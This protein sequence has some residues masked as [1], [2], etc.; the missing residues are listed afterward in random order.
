VRVYS[1]NQWQQLGSD[2][3]GEASYDN[4]GYSTYMNSLGTRLVIGAIY[5]DGPGGK[6]NCGH[7]R[8][9]QWSTS[10]TQLGQDIDG[11]ASSDLFGSSVSMNSVGNIIAVGAPEFNGTAGNN[12]GRVKVFSLNVNNWVQ[13]GSSIDGQTANEY[14]G[15]S[16]SLNA[17]GFTLAIGAP[18]WDGTGA[19]DSGKVRVYSYNGSS[20]NQAGQDLDGT[21]GDQFGRCVSLNAAGNTLAVGAPY[22]GAGD[23]GYVKIYKLSG[24]TWI[25]VGQTITGILTNDQ[26]GY[27]I[28]L[29]EAGNKIAI[30]APNAGSSSRGIAKVYDLIEN[31]W[32]QMGTDIIGKSP[33][34]NAGHSVSLNAVGDRLLIGNPDS[35]S[36]FGLTNTARA[37]Y[38][39][40]SV[41]NQLGPSINGET[42]NDQNG[43]SVSMNAEGDRIAVAAIQS[44]N[45]TNTKPACGQVRVF[46]L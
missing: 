44:N 25:Q 13:V 6:P 5:N 8:V 42:I 27:S 4:S 21:N 45:S 40:G 39:N 11:D 1:L 10:W 2:I 18:F 7:V 28:S 38:W 32:T 41:W 15:S 12:T 46:S 43:F 19:T 31:T 26:I 34:E 22:G 37:Y 9:Y 20:W 23:Q 3:E 14:S 17:D 35:T 36:S 24:A 33:G 16:V 29:N 30:G